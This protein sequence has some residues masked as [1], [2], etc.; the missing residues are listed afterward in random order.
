LPPGIWTHAFTKKEYKVDSSEGLVIK[1]FN[2]PTGEPIV[3][4]ASTSSNGIDSMDMVEL[5]SP[6]PKFLTLE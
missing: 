2:A 5:I 3:F 4:V 1:N 6:T